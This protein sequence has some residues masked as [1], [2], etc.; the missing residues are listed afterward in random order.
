VRTKLI[1]LTLL[2]ILIVA[3]S[4]QNQATTIETLAKTHLGGKYSWG[5]TTPKGF[6]CSGYTQYIYKQVGINL[7]RTAYAQSK[8]GRPI[9]DKSY[10]K[11]DLLFFLTDKK[12]GIPITHIGIYLENN[13]FIHAASSKKGI[14][15]SDLNRSRYGSLLVKATRVLTQEQ[16]EIF[17]PIIFTAKLKEAIYS[18]SRVIFKTKTKTKKE[19]NSSLS[20]LEQAIKSDT[21]VILP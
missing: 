10:Q 12:R 4:N 14:I 7:P 21:K 3:K 11:G 17:Y 15:I 19:N 8:I 2:S 5:G 9:T 20:K 18:N 16:Q 1:L 6:D 13:Q